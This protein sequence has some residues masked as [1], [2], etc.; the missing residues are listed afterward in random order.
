MRFLI[1]IDETMVRLTCEDRCLC[2]NP[3]Y[4]EHY[5]RGGACFNCDGS[6]WHTSPDD[7]TSFPL[8]H[9]S[10]VIAI[11]TQISEAHA[12]ATTAAALNLAADHGR[13]GPHHT[14]D[15][16]LVTCAGCRRALPTK[17]EA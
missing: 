4:R 16:R 8:S 11:L 6:G 14:A 10:Q 9:V 13:D 5:R 15:P 7:G 2:E 3:M 17:N 12:A 1:R